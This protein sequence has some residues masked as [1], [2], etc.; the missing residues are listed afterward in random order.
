MIGLATRTWRV[1]V[2]S[3]SAFVAS[4][5]EGPDGPPSGPCGRIIEVA[6]AAVGAIPTGCHSQSKK[7]RGY[8]GGVDRFNPG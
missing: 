1:K 2:R 8:Q 6:A 4:F 3:V 5:T 7:L